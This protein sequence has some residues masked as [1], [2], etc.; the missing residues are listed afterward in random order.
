LELAVETGHYGAVFSLEFDGDGSLLKSIGGGT[1]IWSVTEGKQPRTLPVTEDG[2]HFYLTSNFDRRIEAGADS[3]TII[4][5][6]MDDGKRIRAL[7]SDSEVTGLKLSPVRTYRLKVFR[8]SAV[9]F[10]PDGR[11]LASSEADGLVKIWE[12]VSGKE[13]ASLAFLDEKGWAIVTPEGRSD[14]SPD[15]MKL[16][17]YAY[18]TETINLGQLKERY[19]EPGL[20][21]KLT[22]FDRGPMREVADFKRID[23]CPSVGGTRVGEDGTGVITVVNRGGGIWRIQVF[24]NDKE[25][26]AGARPNGFD[27]NVSRAALDLD[28]RGHPSWPRS[29]T[30]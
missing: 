8:P 9:V 26:I 5:S 19:Y 6:N 29:R 18:G 24:V 16:M 25:Y 13:L 1:K 28:L 23:L 3:K 20:L 15:G 27:P 10:G 30:A 17:H 2:R 11:L 12:A 7:E 14:A 4:L 22:G 21:A